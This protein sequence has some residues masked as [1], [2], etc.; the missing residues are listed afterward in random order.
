MCVK[1]TLATEVSSTSMKVASITAAAISQGLK[2]GVH[3]RAVDSGPDLLFGSRS[4][5]V[6]IT[7][8]PLSFG[9]CHFGFVGFLFVSIRVISWIVLYFQVGKRSA[10]P[11]E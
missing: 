6:L 1:A 11:P 5:I 8:F 7:D 2:L 4:T 9:I 3:S 10:H